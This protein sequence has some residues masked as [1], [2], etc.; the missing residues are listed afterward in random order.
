VGT[1]NVTVTNGTVSAP[2]QTQVMAH[3]F[4]LFTQDS[5]GSGLAVVQNVVSAAE[6]DINRLTTGAINGITISPAYGSE[7]MVAYGTGMGGAAGDDNAASPDYNFLANGV[8][9]NVIVGGASRLR[10]GRSGQLPASRQRTCQLYH[11][12]TGLGKRRA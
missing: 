3:K 7:Y 2:V 6:Y 5:T 4:N 11:H 10:R 12:F 8:T 9:V 1:Y